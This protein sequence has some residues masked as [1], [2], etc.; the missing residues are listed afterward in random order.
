M[1]VQAD[2]VG[3][4]LCCCTEVARRGEES[5][6]TTL[7]PGKLSMQQSYD[8]KRRSGEGQVWGGPY[9]LSRRSK[10]SISVALLRA[11]GSQSMGLS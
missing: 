5:K 4:V 11:D 1:A 9:N 10:L 7:S 6:K 3:G 8:L 2:L